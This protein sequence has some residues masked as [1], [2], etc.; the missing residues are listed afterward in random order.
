MFM[1]QIPPAFKYKKELVEGFCFPL[2]T[3]YDVRYAR[4][5]VI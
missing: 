2:K 5:G 1:G 4:N 3:E